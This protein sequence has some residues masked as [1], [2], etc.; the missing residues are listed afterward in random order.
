V[1]V[2]TSLARPPLTPRAPLSTVMVVAVRS[3]TT[4]QAA[5]RKAIVSTDPVPLM[6]PPPAK[7]RA[8]SLAPGTLARSQL[9]AVSKAPPPAACHVYVA[10]ISNSQVFSAANVPR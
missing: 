4:I 3:P 6:P 5:A 8:V 9:A 10:A 2:A 1:L 7:N